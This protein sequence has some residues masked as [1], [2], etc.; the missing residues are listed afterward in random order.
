MNV[1]VSDVSNII[2]IGPVGVH[3]LD[4]LKNAMWIERVVVAENKLLDF[5]LHEVPVDFKS[6]S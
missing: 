6:R 3:E 1:L 4:G 5:G 2:R